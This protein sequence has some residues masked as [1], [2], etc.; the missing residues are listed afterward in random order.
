VGFES[1]PPKGIQRVPFG[2][3]LNMTN[4]NYKYH[5]ANLRELALAI[6]HTA[7]LSRS[8]IAN[9]DPERSLRSLL[10]LYSFLLGAWAECRLQKLLSEPN[11]FSDE[12]RA[13][14]LCSESQLER[15]QAA[16]DL[17]FR[18]H[19]K[20][21]RA[22]LDERVLGVEH[23]ARRAALH[24]ALDRDLRI[25]IEIRNKLA[26]GQWAYP[27]TSDGMKVDS[28]KYKLI[29]QENLLS[30]RFKHQ[31]ISHLADAVH[32]LIVSPET[33]KRDFDG[34]FRR[35]FQARSNIENRDYGKYERSLV[36][37]RQRARR[38][39]V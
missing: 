30:L 34:H 18:H 8:T 5:V 38:N 32:D 33:F 4:K 9:G 26:H 16:I 27:F 23:A 6:R 39:Q 28:K 2:G 24:D 21:A 31:L 13:T 20:I 14:I 29:D 10:R 15:W 22:D 25:V 3:D 1:P 36:E 19:H 7:R 37:R 12:Q 17:A 11:G 35:L